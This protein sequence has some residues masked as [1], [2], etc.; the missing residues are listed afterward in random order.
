MDGELPKSTT[1]DSLFQNLEKSGETDRVDR[2]APKCIVLGNAP[3]SSVLGRLRTLSESCWFEVVR[4]FNYDARQ[5]GLISDSSK[6]IDTFGSEGVAQKT[7]KILYQAAKAVSA[8]N[9]DY[10]NIGGE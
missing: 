1:R 7:G 9:F 8:Q 2:L 10:V 3:Y 4:R 5:F 6:K